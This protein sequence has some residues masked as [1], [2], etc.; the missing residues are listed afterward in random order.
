MQ[1][2]LRTRVLALRVPLRAAVCQSKL[3]PPA[4]LTGTGTIDPLRDLHICCRKNRRSTSSPVRNRNPGLMIVRG[5][6]EKS[7]KISESTILLQEGTQFQEVPMAI[8]KSNA[9]EGLENETTSKGVTLSL[10]KQLHYD[11]KMCNPNDLTKIAG[12]PKPYI[13]LDPKEEAAF[14]EAFNSYHTPQ[15]VLTILDT[16][17]SQEVTPYVSFSILKKLFELESNFGFRNEGRSWVI[18]SPNG[19]QETF[20]R[21]AIIGRLMD[22]IMSTDNTSLLL[23]TLD[24][25][26]SE[27]SQLFYHDSDEFMNY[28]NRLCECILVKVT[29]GKLSLLETCRAVCAFGQMTS[30]KN[31]Q[32]DNKFVDKLWVGILDKSNEIT[33]D[34]IVHVFR[35]VQ[36]FTKCQRLVC[37]L[38]EKNMKTLWWRMDS[39]TAAQICEI[40][41]TE[42]KANDRWIWCIPGQLYSLLSKSTSL[43]MHQIQEGQLLKIIKCF[44]C[45]DFCDQVFR[46]VS[47]QNEC[48]TSELIINYAS[49]F[50]R[51][52]IST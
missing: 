30:D 42:K 15:E 24:V 29:E 47:I 21:A 3:L 12:P 35:T 18:T 39:E 25:L 4:T 36:Y 20:A 17:P 16:I 34:N 9:C 11:F 44:H 8:L 41:G 23:D 37:G 50:S 49:K 27:K 32:I 51:P 7:K 48:V 1:P 31:F 43:N 46:K 26:R 6:S 2:C 19:K 22:I 33:A 13:E 10:Q 38:V 45:H 5:L 28:R 40:I 52:L 14:V